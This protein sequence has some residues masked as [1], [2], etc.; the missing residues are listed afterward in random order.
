M[1]PIEGR[2]DPRGQP[3]DHDAAQS[4]H[5]TLAAMP[6]ATVMA[7]LL[8]Q[9]F[10]HDLDPIIVDLPGA[11]AIRW[12]GVAYLTRFAVALVLLRWMGRTGRIIIPPQWAFDTLTY[13]VVG[14]I[15]GGRLGYVLFYD[16]FRSLAEGA[17][18]LL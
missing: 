17:T 6:D 14:V 3:G 16:L 13:G 5:A 10:L 15:I 7:L 12:Y 11:L 1:P 2:A 8:A 18:P 4:S 9:S